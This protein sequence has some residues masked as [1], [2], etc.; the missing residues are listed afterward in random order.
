MTQTGQQN[1]YDIKYL[2]G[3]GSQISVKNQRIVLKN[4]IDVFTEN[5]ETEEYVPT[6]EEAFGICSPPIINRWFLISRK[7]DVDLTVPKF[8]M[9][10]SNTT[11][12]KRWQ[13]PKQNQKQRLNQSLKNLRN[14]N[15]GLKNGL[16]TF[17]IQSCHP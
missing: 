5:Q 13:K 8:N 2:H 15:R 12:H 3:Y 6:G 4:G 14:K 11:C 10:N 7:S 16:F 17:L 9:L 1:H